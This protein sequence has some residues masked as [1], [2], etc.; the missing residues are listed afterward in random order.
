MDRNCSIGIISEDY[1]DFLTDSE[2]SPYEELINNEICAIAIDKTISAV[3]I[4]EYLVSARS[5]EKYG[6]KSFIR[7]F[8]LM[9]EQSLEAS[10][11]ERLRNIPGLNLRGQGVLIGI[12]DTGI[13]YTHKAFIKADGT[14]KIVSIWDQSIQSSNPPEGLYYG[15]EYTRDEINLALSS[16]DPLSIVPSSDEIGHGTFLAGIAVGNEDITNDFSG[17]VP[18][19]ELIV[20]KLK[21]PKNSVRDFYLVSPDTVCYQEND[22]MLGVKYLI[23]TAVK[24]NRPISIC[25]GLGTSQGSHDATDSLS[26]YLSSL[27]QL[28]N[29]TVTIAAGNEGNSRHHYEGILPRGTNEDIVELNIGPNEQGLYFEIWGEIPNT[30]GVGITSPSGEVVP[31]IAPRLNE[32][33]EID[34]IFEITTINIYFQL[35]G[36]RSGSQLV[37]VRFM[38]PTEGIWRIT[39][40]KTDRTLPL[41]FNIWLPISSF[42]GGDTFF[43]NST[44]Y[45]T[46][47]DPANSVIPIVAT[48]YDMT[49]D[50][51]YINASRGFTRADRISPTLAAPGVNIIGPN[52][53][54]GY[55]I[56]SGTSVAAAHTTGLAAMLLEWG[57]VRGTLDHMDGTDVKNLLL[58][59]A[60][61]SP[62]Q[63]YPNR[64]WGFGIV[65]I[66]GAFDKLRLDMILD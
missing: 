53:A 9:D 47:T 4:P 49:N 40:N 15:T 33:R 41:R 8:G 42:I 1:R 50:S 5:L 60:V 61:R 25:I 64:E 29:I 43:I 30:F 12:V 6:Y 23:D 24:Y 19:A 38:N 27:A 32:R 56:M 54:N 66:Y 11:V 7:L 26:I 45:I 59:G 31:V 22:I 13:D 58:R 2:L 51:L 34:F 57:I 28:E 16:G 62:N 37:I 3:Y 17:V 52:L 63:T 44:P 20:V 39:I 18:D 14:T 21:P 65:N 10:G 48:A 36:S 55:T 35:V 46:L